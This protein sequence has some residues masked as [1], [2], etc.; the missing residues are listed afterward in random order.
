MR[1]ESLRVRRTG[2]FVVR[3]RRKNYRWFTLLTYAFF[4]I[5][6]AGCQQEPPA[7]KTT[8]APNEPSPTAEAP[9]QPTVPAATEQFNV[10]ASNVRWHPPPT[11]SGLPEQG[12]EIAFL[13]GHPAT[14]GPFTIRLRFQPGARLMPHTHPSD[15]NI[16]VISGT[17]HQGIGDKFDRAK[18]EAI[19]AGSFVHRKPGIPHFVWFDEETVLQF[20]GIGPFGISYTGR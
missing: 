16:T 6:T 11:A 3:P 17:L 2:Q 9:T 4:L 12:V 8:R 13:Q 7:P 5:A 15:E 1:R 18:T 20:H 10:L 19:P 14:M